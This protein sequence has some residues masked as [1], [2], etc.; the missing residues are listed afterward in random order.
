MK[1]TT[2]EELKAAMQQYVPHTSSSNKEVKDGHVFR[3]V[4]AR[5][6]DELGEMVARESRREMIDMFV[7]GIPPM[8]RELVN[9]WLES[10]E[11]YA[12]NSAGNE[13]TEEEV[14]AQRPKW[15]ELFNDFYGPKIR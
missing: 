4:A 3:F 1:I 11:D 13:A 12:L 10:A 9:E 6:A 8:S 7:E 14:D 5:N 15:D 2:F